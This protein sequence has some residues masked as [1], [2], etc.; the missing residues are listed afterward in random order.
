MIRQ[1]K[2]IR[3]PHCLHRFRTADIEDDCTS[4]SMPI[5]CPICGQKVSLNLFKNISIW[6]K[7]KIAGMIKRDKGLI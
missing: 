6:L 7:E 5:Y 2:I 4:L 1:F 3:C